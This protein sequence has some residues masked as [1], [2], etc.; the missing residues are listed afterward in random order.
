MLRSVDQP[1]AARGKI[2]FDLNRDRR[3]LSARQVVTPDVTGVLEDDRVLA[4]RRELDVEILEV[5]QLLGL[6]LVR[7]IE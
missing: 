5:R 3:G 2:L 6:L 4:E 1:G 7:S